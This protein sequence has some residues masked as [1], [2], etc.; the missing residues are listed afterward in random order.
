MSF[1]YPKQV[2]HVLEIILKE[3]FDSSVAEH[4]YGQTR[5]P[6]WEDINLNIASIKNTFIVSMH[7][8]IKSTM[9]YCAKESVK[10]S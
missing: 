4:Y 2:S 6:R 8:K 7:Q 9:L 10:K 5:T 1:K 3:K